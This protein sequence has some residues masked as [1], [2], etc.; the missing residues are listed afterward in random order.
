MKSPC[1]W[2]T[3]RSVRQP[4][5]ALDHSIL[6]SEHHRRTTFSLFEDI[7]AGIFAR[8]LLTS[9]GLVRKRSLCVLLRSCFRGRGVGVVG[10]LSWVMPAFG[11]G[12][13]LCC[14]LGRCSGIPS[15]I[16]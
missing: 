9:I 4:D 3:R 15:I 8:A 2:S 11:L 7:V 12:F 5:D 6:L 10:F 13:V 14:W 16:I 1:S